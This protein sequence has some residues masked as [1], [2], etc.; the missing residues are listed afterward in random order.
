MGLQSAHV[1]RGLHRITA[2]NMG[3]LVQ[4]TELGRKAPRIHV[5]MIDV[6]VHVNN[7]STV[8]Q[9]PRIR[10]RDYNLSFP[11]YVL[12]R[13]QLER[14][15]QLACSVRN[16][17]HFMRKVVVVICPGSHFLTSAGV[18]GALRTRWPTA[19]WPENTLS[20][21]DCSV[22]GRNCILSDR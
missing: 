5:M 20:S 4:V 22:T 9:L 15:A 7:M 1:E 14:W 10:Q 21:N 19:Q 13:F 17:G 18:K 6:R 2:V 11:W 16:P 3:I 12:F 8:D